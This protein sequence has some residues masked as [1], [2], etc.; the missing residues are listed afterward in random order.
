MATDTVPT[1]ASQ[2]G[3]DGRRIEGAEAG[4][5]VSTLGTAEAALLPVSAAPRS[6]PPS[7]APRSAAPLP[8]APLS[9]APSPPPAGPSGHPAPGSGTGCPHGGP[10]DTDTALLA[11]SH[12][13]GDR[14]ACQPG[15]RPRRLCP[16]QDGQ[17]I[18]DLVPGAAPGE[19]RTRMGWGRR[20]FRPQGWASGRGECRPPR[21]TL[22]ARS[23]PA[24]AS[25]AHQPE[26]RRAE[27]GTCTRPAAR[28]GGWGAGWSGVKPEPEPGSQPHRLQHHGRR[29]PHV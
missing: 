9:A 7:A 5:R 19:A 20:C 15:P 16:Q 27:G 22:P 23:S 17:L 10:A 28:G 13:H 11:P 25:P 3:R 6:A 8:A 1:C 24:V 12:L 18:T 14:G 4:A 2:A 21:G 26:P 29:S